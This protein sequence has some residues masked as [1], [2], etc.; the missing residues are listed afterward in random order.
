MSEPVHAC[1]CGAAY[2]AA[3]WTALPLLGHQPLPDGTTAE[4]RN[5]RACQSTR[6]VVC[7]ADMSPRI[8]AQRSNGMTWWICQRCGHRWLARKAGEPMTCPRGRPGAATGGC[9]TPFWRVARQQKP[10]T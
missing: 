2:S 4:L 3:E 5:C 10:A 7:G 8:Y 1:S 6:A 9:G